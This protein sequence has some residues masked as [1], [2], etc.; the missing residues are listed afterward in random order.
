[1]SQRPLAILHVDGSLTEYLDK[2]GVL[3]K[4]AGL[5]GYLVVNG[6]I[7]DKFH[8][9]LKDVP[10]MNHHEEYAIIE[11]LKWLKEKKIHSVRIKTDSLTSVHLFNHQKK[12]LAKA[13]KFFL[14]QY[15]MLEYSFEWVEVLHHSRTDDDLSHQLSRTYM[16]DLP[17]NITKLHAENNKKKCDYDIAGDAAFHCERDITQILVSSMKEIQLLVR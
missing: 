2:R 14:L 9:T 17:K 3:H 10:H 13:D 8:K 12:Q 11:G 7:V 16:Q 4:V 6:K 1:M 15:M 5:G